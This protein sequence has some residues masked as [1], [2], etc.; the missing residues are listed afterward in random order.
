MDEVNISA[1]SRETLTC[2]QSSYCYTSTDST[3]LL[4]ALS[5]HQ[6]ASIILSATDSFGVTGYYY[7]TKYTTPSEFDTSWTNIAETTSFSKSISAS[8]YN[9]Q[10]IYV[11]FKDG[12]GNIS[13]SYNDYV[14]SY[15]GTDYTRPNGSISINGSSSASSTVSV[16]L[17]ASD[18]CGVTGYLPLKVLQ[19]PHSNSNWISVTSTT[20]LSKTVNYTFTS[21]GSSNT[22]YAWYKDSR[23]NVSYRV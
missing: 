23:G 10:Y 3:A 21:L 5:L 2:P 22:L 20:N 7:N 4:V 15:S 8:P 6:V 11:R 16:N 17:S 9:G 18:G 14:Y 13:P 12:A 19:H 1:Y